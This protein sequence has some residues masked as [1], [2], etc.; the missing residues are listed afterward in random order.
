MSKLIKKIGVKPLIELPHSIIEK[1]KDFS[2]LDTN[3]TYVLATLYY[4]DSIGKLSSIKKRLP[5]YTSL[6][7][8]E[9]ERALNILAHLKVIEYSEG[10]V[11]LRIRPIKYK[12]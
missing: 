10:Q 9:C 8:E 5:Y 11:I 12:R 3:V 2:G 6:E 1:V 4:L 7:W